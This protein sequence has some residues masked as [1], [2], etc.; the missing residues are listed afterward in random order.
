MGSIKTLDRAVLPYD[1]VTRAFCSF[2]TASVL[3]DDR[4]DMPPQED[5]PHGSSAPSSSRQPD[6]RFSTSFFS[7]RPY[8]TSP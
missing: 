2:Q 5:C 7:C 6:S 8:T 4:S 1:Y 3:R